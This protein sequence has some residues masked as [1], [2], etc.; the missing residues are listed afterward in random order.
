[1]EWGSGSNCCLVRAPA[2]MSFL[3]YMNV[4]GM[5]MRFYLSSQPLMTP[6]PW[7]LLHIGCSIP[8][9]NGSTVGNCLLF[10]CWE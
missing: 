7:V 9:F 5:R 10:P 3:F 1:M 4:S 2:L 6:A 8:W